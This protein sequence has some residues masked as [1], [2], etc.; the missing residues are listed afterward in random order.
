MLFPKKAM[1]RETAVRGD[2]ETRGECVE[3]IGGGE[4]SERSILKINT[5]TQR[6]REREHEQARVVLFPET[7]RHALGHSPI[8]A[9][10]G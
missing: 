8:Y 5:S 2:S 4:I 9:D 6:G 10:G 7:R 1:V 3:W